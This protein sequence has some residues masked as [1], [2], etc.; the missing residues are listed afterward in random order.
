MIVIIKG[1]SLRIPATVTGTKSVI[2]SIEAVIKK[3][4]RGEVPLDTSPTVATLTVTDYD[5]EG[6]VD[7]YIFSLLNTSALTVGTYY[8]NY[9]Y[10]VA[11]VTYKGDPMKVVVKEG[12]I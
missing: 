8:V 10:I 4:N 7:G 3:S 6:I 5:A 12:V 11:G 9:K 2:S 1:E